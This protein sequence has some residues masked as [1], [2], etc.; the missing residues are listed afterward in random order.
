MAH[1]CVYCCDLILGRVY[2]YNG[3]LPYH[4][5]CFYNLE[6]AFRRNADK[7]ANHGQPNTKSDE[8]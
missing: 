1:K 3:G 8:L 4:P 5:M 2:T 6:M 7:I